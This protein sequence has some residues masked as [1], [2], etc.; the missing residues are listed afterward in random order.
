MT[1]D[2]NIP[3]SPREVRPA[4][5]DWLDALLA[6][7]AAS[8]PHTAYIED[9]GFTASVMAKLPAARA[10]VPYRWIVPAMGVLGFLIG[11]VLFSGGENLT[12]SLVRLVSFE[13]FSMQKLFLVAA[14]LGILYWLGV[15]AAWQQR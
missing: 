7:D 5:E 4:E 12:V 2:R 6:R 15:A 1:T 8:A 9:A 11:V 13:S 10:R 3:S 14:P